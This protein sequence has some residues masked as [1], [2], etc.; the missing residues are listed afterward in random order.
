MEISA[1][2][3]DVLC[4]R[5]DSIISGYTLSSVYS[6]EGGALLRLRHESKKEILIAISSFATWLTTKNLTLP[7]A[8][9]FASE[10]REIVERT[11]I[12]K[13]LQAGDERIAEFI[14]QSKS[15]EEFSLFAEFFAGGNLILTD[16]KHAILRAKRSQR[17]KHRNVI[18]GEKYVL[19][20]SRGM[21]LNGITAESLGLLAERSLKRG[22]GDLSLVKWFG[23]NVGTSRKFVEEIFH[24]SG[25]NPL[26]SL[27]SISKDQVN[28]LAKAANDLRGKLESSKKGYLLVPTEDNETDQE[29]D[30]CSLVPNQWKLLSEAGKAAISEFPTLSEALDEAQVRAIVFEEQSKA[31]R[32]IRSKAA[33]LDSAISKQDAIYVKNKSIAEELRQ[34]ASE[35]IHIQPSAIDEK[36]VKRFE[37]LGIVEKD[38][39][40]GANYRFVNDPRAFLSSF[41]T[42]SAIASRLF[43]EAKRLESSNLAILKIRQELVERREELSL[44]TRLSQERASKRIVIERRA[45]E[46]FERYRWFLTSDSRLA[47]GGRDSTSNS[48][49]INKYV[50]P[51]DTVFHADL[52]GSPF[53]VLKNNRSQSNDL[54]EKID[55]ELAQATVSFSRAWKDELGSADAFWVSPNQIKKSAPSG[56]YLPRGSFFIE[57]KKNFVKHV[58][59]ELAIGLMSSESLPHEAD[60]Q[61]DSVNSVEL[62]VVVCGPEKS[63]AGYCLALVKIAPGRE[64]SSAIAR[65]IKQILVGKVKDESLKEAVK[66]MSLDDIIRVL[67]SGTYKLVSEK[68]NG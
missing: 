12:L 10:I 31:S 62:P 13:V 55:L 18:V 6:I 24:Q 2:E 33:E 40:V 48:I 58:R 37:S 42:N 52:H 44:Q 1:T 39:T 36:T 43:D 53:F 56:E 51:N 54:S 57:G 68:Q 50:A 28:L 35:M 46:W 7:Q 20:P 22:E 16:E 64:K 14:F 11:K 59:V 19:P 27:A 29:I 34:I 67:P 66:K 61:K 5:I 25:L 65:R 21:S 9:S 15:G 17:F 3:I 8:D 23:R 38:P 32:E 47:V 49:I 30:V 45:R 26:S 41:S 60:L 63:L 4:R